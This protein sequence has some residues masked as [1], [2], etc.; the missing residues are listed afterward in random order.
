MPPK[1]GPFT[2][3]EVMEGVRTQVQCVV[4]AGDLPLKL[5]W[6]KDD[7]H[8]PANLGVVVTEDDYTSTLAIATVTA[9]HAGQYTCLA[10]NQAKSTKQSDRLVV[11]GTPNQAKERHSRFSSSKSTVFTS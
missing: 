9:Q 4:Q 5:E 10:T 1:L 8:I 2:F 3:G 11:T 6:R 7:E